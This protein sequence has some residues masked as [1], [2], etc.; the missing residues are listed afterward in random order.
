[1]TKATT[2]RQATILLFLQDHVRAGKP[3][4][5]VREIGKQFGI[6]SPNGVM[7]HLKALEAKGLITR[8]TSKARSIQLV[9]NAAPVIPAWHPRPTCPGVWLCPPSKKIAQWVSLALSQDDINRGA[10]FLSDAVFG[11]IPARPEV[12][13]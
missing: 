7:C 2:D 13:P 1:M 12:K 8:N 9:G 11:P 4:P 6:R 3:M 10:P 5:T